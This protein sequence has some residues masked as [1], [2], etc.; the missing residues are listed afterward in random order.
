MSTELRGTT[1]H[2]LT[3]F[4]G[5]KE[6]GVCLQVTTR[7]VSFDPQKPGFVVVNEKE[8]LELAEAL[9]QF[10]NNTREED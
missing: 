8:A 10:V 9:L 4:W 3:R 2:L 1:E 7:T 5:G 6:R